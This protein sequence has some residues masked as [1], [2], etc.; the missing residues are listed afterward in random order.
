MRSSLGTTNLPLSP[1]PGT[2]P[3]GVFA[4]VPP[5]CIVAG[6]GVVLELRIR[7]GICAAWP[8]SAVFTV[9]SGDMAT[10]ISRVDDAWTEFSRVVAGTSEGCRRRLELGC[11]GSGVQFARRISHIRLT[12]RYILDG[13]QS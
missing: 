2:I 6:P 3:P 4:Y 13:V 1:A 12:L 5:L 8:P 11:W 10:M 7:G 9:T